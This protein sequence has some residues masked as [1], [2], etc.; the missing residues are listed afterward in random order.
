MYT[1]V[2]GK[3]IT[4]TCHSRAVEN[5][6]EPP[7]AAAEP[8]PRVILQRLK[9]TAQSALRVC[10]HKRVRVFLIMTFFNNMKRSNGE[11]ELESIR[12]LSPLYIDTSIYTSSSSQPSTRIDD[13]KKS[14]HHDDWSCRL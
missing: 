10:E 1:F 8:L 14:H 4:Y 11:K 3:E 6:K 9:K 13:D 5:T 2:R 7:A 12:F